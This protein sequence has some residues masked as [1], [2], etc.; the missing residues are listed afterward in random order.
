MNRPRFT[1]LAAM[2]FAAAASRLMPHLP[3]ATPIAAIALF[4]GAF[5]ADKRL[6]FLVPLAALFLSDLVLGLHGQ[7]P[8][9]YAS[10][11]MTVCLGFWLRGQ[12]WVLPIAAATLTSSVLF[13]LVTNF[14][15]WA[16][17][18]LYPKTLEGLGA[19]YV[20]AIPFFR[21]TVFGDAFYAALLFGGFALAE[22]SFP[23]LRD[24]AALNAA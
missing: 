21:Y 8:G 6:A 22:K 4:G 11:A 12:R 16:T 23:L 13:Y 19:C 5:F 24:H 7:M 2:I 9:V 3:N 10:F 18:G 15:V 20:A 1:L 14:N 17:G